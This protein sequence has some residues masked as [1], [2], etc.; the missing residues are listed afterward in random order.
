MAIQAFL[1]K[2]CTS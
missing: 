1:K 2:V